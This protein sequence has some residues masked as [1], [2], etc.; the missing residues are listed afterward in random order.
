MVE[1]GAPDDLAKR[2]EPLL[3]AKSPWRYSARELAAL[4]DLRKGDA[5]KARESFT[6]LAD[7][8]K[9]PAGVRARAVE[10]L[11]ALKQ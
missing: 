6:K 11:R 7:D 1:T 9:T 2:L 8:P 3:G 4:V 10:M 5:D